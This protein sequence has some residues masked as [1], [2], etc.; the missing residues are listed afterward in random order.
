MPVPS[1]PPAVAPAAAHARETRTMRLALHA[2]ADAAFPLFGPVR[3]T[4]WSP[5]WAPRFVWPAAPA[6]GPEGAVFTTDGPDS[7]GRLWVMTDYDP[8]ARLV[9]YVIVHGRALVG[10]LSIR[11][12]PAGPAACTAEVTYRFTGLTAEGDGFVARWVVHFPRMQEHWEEALN[13]RLA[14]G[15]AAGGEAR[16]TGTKP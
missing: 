1:P 2:A 3:E 12:E 16:D 14:A 11:V 7:A 15:G 9:R 10:E 8:A 4:E 13:A 5:D 6:Q